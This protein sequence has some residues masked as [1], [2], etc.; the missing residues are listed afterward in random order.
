ME[1]KI[2]GIQD[3]DFENKQGER[4]VGVNLFCSSEDDYVH[5]FRTD[6]FFISRRLTPPDGFKVNSYYDIL[7]GRRGNVDKISFI[8]DEVL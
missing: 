2:L 3:I 6:K 1:V 4:I 5:G 8:G 7:F